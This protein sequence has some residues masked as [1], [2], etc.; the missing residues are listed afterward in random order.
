MSEEESGRECVM[1]TGA[2]NR[3][4]EV[5]CLEGNRTS[6]ISLWPVTFAFFFFFSLPCF[7]VLVLFI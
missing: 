1:G 6:V 7:S 5:V 2:S 4:K 3:R